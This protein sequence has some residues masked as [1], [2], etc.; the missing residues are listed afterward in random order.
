LFKVTPAI[1]GAQQTANRNSA[2]SKLRITDMR[3]CRVAANYDYPIVEIQPG[4]VRVGRGAGCGRGGHRADLIGVVARQRDT[5]PA[6]PGREQIYFTD[7]FVGHGAAGFWAI[8]TA[9]DPAKY[10]SAVRAAIAKLDPHL[11][12]T[13]MQPMDALVEHAQASTRFS[14][15]ISSVYLPA[16]AR[17]WPAWDSTACS[18]RWCGSARPRSASAWR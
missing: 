3:A 15:L 12:L 13:E 2:P 5:S 8:H 18:R 10:A 4:C 11:L 16:W 7:G 9:G 17:C 14:L 6:V 1:V